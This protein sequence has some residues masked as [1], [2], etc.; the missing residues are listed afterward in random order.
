MNEPVGGLSPICAN[1][2]VNV[3]SATGVETRIDSGQLHDAVF[4]GERSA[5]EPGLRAVEGSFVVRAV[6]AGRVG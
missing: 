2:D 5:A 4:V 6:R 1:H 3:W